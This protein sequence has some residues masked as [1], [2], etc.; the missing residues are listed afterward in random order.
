VTLQ[1][2]YECI[3]LRHHIAHD[4]QFKQ[5]VRFASDYILTWQGIDRL[6]NLHPLERHKVIPVGVAKWFAEASSLLHDEQWGPN[7]EGVA[8]LSSNKGR[9]VSKLL[10][11][12]N[13]HSVRFST[14]V[15]RYQRFLRF[16]LDAQNSPEIDLMVRS[17][18][19]KRTLEK[20]QKQNQITFLEGSLAPRDFNQFDLFVSPPST[21]ILDAILTG[22]P[23]LVW[24]DAARFGD[25]RNYRGLDMVTDIGELVNSRRD[26]RSRLR[27]LKWAADNTSAFN[28]VPQ[29]WNF[30]VNLAA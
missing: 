28:G 25:V 20:N 10:I 30:L 21:I 17:H 29:A 15:S 23:S 9:S 16:I 26:L 14:V 2:G 11:A 6:P 4:N 1:H 8:S 18:P 13:L 22:L 27:A 12:E 3:G 7:A 24:S 19:G 5:G